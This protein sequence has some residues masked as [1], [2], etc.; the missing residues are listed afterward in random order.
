LI[1]NKTGDQKEEE[2]M[3]DSRYLE[4]CLQKRFTD[5]IHNYID[6]GDQEWLGWNWRKFR[7]GV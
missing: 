4:I 5:D 1:K 2:L 3:F 7:I 6:E